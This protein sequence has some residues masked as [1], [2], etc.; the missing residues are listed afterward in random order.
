MPSIKDF[1]T[2][3]EWVAAVERWASDPR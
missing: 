1:A 3:E 2:I